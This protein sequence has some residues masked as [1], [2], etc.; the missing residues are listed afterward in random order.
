MAMITEIAGGK[1]RLTNDEL[2]RRAAKALYEGD[3]VLFD[4]LPRLIADVIKHRV[5]E[6]FN[7]DNFADFALDHTS[8][9][10]G[11]NT[12]QRLWL[13]RCAMD[14]HG[15]HIEE[16][17]GVLAKVEQM[18]KLIPVSERGSIAN[19]N[20]N[21][22]EGLAKDCPTLDK[23]TYLPSRQKSTDGALLRLRKSHPAMFR[24]VLDGE[25]TARQGMIEAR[26]AD[27]EPVDRVTNLGR[28]LSALRK[29]TEDE[30]VEFNRLMRI[31]GF[32]RK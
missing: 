25:M 5:W 10:L 20:G 28:A 23:I 11:V 24:R 7:H 19:A 8:N 29:M 6:S 18:V 22:L 14:V 27:G 3:F 2:R 1:V 16:W 31:G 32:V 9:G 12:N 15:A 4:S 13:L 21:S 26:R 17:A 30:L